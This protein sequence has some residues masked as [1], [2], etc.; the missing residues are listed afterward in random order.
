MSVWHFTKDNLYSHAP[1]SHGIY[2]LYEASGNLIYVGRAAGDGV[3]IYSSLINHL[4]GNEGR[5]TQQAAFF[6]FEATERA[7]TREVE[8]LEDYKRRNGR[9]PRCNE[10]IG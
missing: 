8:V 2:S 7:T 5:C 9:L 4:M 10:R 1:L 6:S 3:T